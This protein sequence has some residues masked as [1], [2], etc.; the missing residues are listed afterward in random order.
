MRDSSRR[1]LP[2]IVALA[3]GLEVIALSV[4]I[5]SRSEYREISFVSQPLALRPSAPTG[6]ITDASRIVQTF[7]AKRAN[8]AEVSLFLSNYRQPNQSAL[9]LTVSHAR[10]DKVLRVSTAPPG[11][12]ADNRYYRFAFPAIPNSKDRSFVVTLRSPDAKPGHAVTAWL[13]DEDPYPQGTAIVNGTRRPRQ[14]LVLALSYRIGGAI[15]ELVNRAS[16]YKP[17]F[18][19][20]GNL[21]VLAILALLITVFAAFVVASSVLSSNGSSASP[22]HALH[23]SRRFNSV[24]GS[25]TATLEP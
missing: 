1:L 10:T 18:F 25:P 21:K 20:G 15:V 9:V 13:S 22:A 8:L 16:Q 5:L 6:E 12:V 7:R 4:G 23:E 14:D 2:T 19:K 3:I 11:A 24:R 17:G